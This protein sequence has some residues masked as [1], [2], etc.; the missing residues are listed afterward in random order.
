MVSS[1]HYC[2]HSIETPFTI[3]VSS[4]VCTY[5]HCTC[6]SI[7]PDHSLLYGGKSNH[8]CLVFLLLSRARTRTHTLTRV[9]THTL[10]RVH[11]H[12]LT[13]TDKNRHRL[14]LLAPEVPFLVQFMEH[15]AKDEDRSDGVTACCAGR[16]SIATVHQI[17]ITLCTCENF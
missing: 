6:T 9:H 3:T 13:H 15:V 8:P 4:M 17:H 5:I 12:T 2:S 10:T 14:D 11:T 7:Q 16:S 1:C